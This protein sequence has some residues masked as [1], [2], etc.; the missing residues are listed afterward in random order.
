MKYLILTLLLIA[1]QEMSEK[2]Y[3]SV[4][5]QA[6]NYQVEVPMPDETRCDLVSSTHAIEVEW[7]S[8][9]KEAPA[10]AVLYSIWTGKKPGVILLIKN[11]REDKVHILRCK[12]VCEK[13]G[14]T[15]EVYTNGGFRFDNE[16]DI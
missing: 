1:P 13:L 11:Q 3:A 6:R 12:M 5:G 10:Q 8:K 15:M 9:W 16:N 2:Q 14:I 4:I 7:A